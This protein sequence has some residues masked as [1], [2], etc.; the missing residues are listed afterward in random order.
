M[1]LDLTGRLLASVSPV[2]LFANG[3]VGVWYDPSDLT[4]LFTDSAGTTPVTAPGQTVGLMLDKSQ[5]LVLGPELVTNGDFSGGTTGWT[6]Q[7][8]WAVTGG[9]AVAAATSGSIYGG[10]VTTVSGRT[11]RIDFDVVSYTSGALS[12]TVGAN[13]STNAELTGAAMAAGR[14]TVYVIAGAT[15][16][17]GV[18]FFGGAVTATIDNISVK[19]LA[20]N[21]ATQATTA[22]R[23]TYGI[24]PIT[25]TRNLLTRTEEF[26]N[27]A[28]SKT[29]LTVTAN[30][31]VA[32]DGTMTADAIVESTATSA[33]TIYRLPGL[34]VATYTHSF[35][36]KANGRTQ[37]Q[38][39]Q[40]SGGN[41]R[42]TL[43]GAGTAVALGANTV[44]ISLV[45]DGWYRCSTT[46]T[47]TAAFG[48]YV[49][50]YNGSTTSYTG[51]GTSGI[52]VW[53]AQLEASATATAYQKVVTQY[54]VTE[55]GVQSV[56]YLA[57]DGVDD[58]MVTNT[59]TPAIDKA[60][61]FAGVRKLSDAATGLLLETSVSSSSQN[62]SVG[63]LAP[64]SPTTDRYDFRSR[65]TAI[66]A[67]ATTSAAFTAPVT[68]VLTGIGDIAA[69]TSV[70][71]INGTQSATA[72]TDQGTG[73]YLAYPLYLGRRGGTTIP[74]NGRIYSMIVRFGANLTDGQI[75]STE[76]WVNAKVGAY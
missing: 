10:G 2:A 25:G 50:L 20:G 8:G 43:S 11:Y 47:V 61:V 27:A 64:S 28:W 69:D 60:Q 75:T 4:T 6:A 1:S 52:Y 30:A 16:S 23:P 33:H 65:G 26:D 37:L 49:N 15:S 36:A 57:F 66:S 74:F 19:L 24:N 70:L 22:S 59:I 44:A 54:E 45:G 21:H 34:G 40:E 18:E 9:G 31:V 3:E 62:G 13:Y 41:A 76:S 7:T 58:S 71:R 63:I 17:R 35:Y 72:S 12:I 38:V 56:S 29:A 67:V 32:P 14:K 73:N 51:D 42:F 68:N 48:I 46:F 39:E 53:G 5:G 55:A